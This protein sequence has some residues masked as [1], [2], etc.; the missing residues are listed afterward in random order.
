[1]TALTRDPD[2]ASVKALPADVKIV[3][4][5]YTSVEALTATLRDGSFDA[6]VILINRLQPQAQ[7][8][9]IDAAA[10]TGSNMHI[11][12]SSFGIDYSHPDVKRLQAPLIEDKMA[13][14]EHLFSVARAGK[15]TYTAINAGMFL[16]WALDRGQCVDLRRDKKPTMLF[17]GGNVKLSASTLDFI[18]EAVANALLRKEEVVNRVLY[19]HTAA[20]TQQQILGYAKELAP[21]ME[22][23]TVPVDTA[24]LEKR[25]LEEIRGGASGPEAARP[26]MVRTTFGLGLG[27][28]E[29]TDNALLGL[30]EWT[31]DDLKALIAKYIRR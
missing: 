8:N 22:I 6:L 13:M 30:R 17:D 4:A 23:Q 25:T 10:A 7:I 2:S 21:D 28:F 24:E 19:V 20:I 14:E 18:G 9:L 29:K 16:D 15:L 5:D 12:P 27:L 11:I 26:L 3:R 31:E 1:M